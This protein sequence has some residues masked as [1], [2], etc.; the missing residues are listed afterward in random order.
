MVSRDV[1]PFCLAAGDRARIKTL[2]LTGLH[3]A[4]FK[5]DEIDQL[6]VSFRRFFRR[7]GDSLSQVMTEFAEHSSALIHEWTRFVHESERG[8]MGCAQAQDRES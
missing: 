2:N 1:L 6:R 8:I 3:R 5:Q 4:G 7:N